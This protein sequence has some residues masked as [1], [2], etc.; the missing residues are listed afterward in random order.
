[1]D[2][3]PPPGMRWAHTEMGRTLVPARSSRSRRVTP[4]TALKHKCRAALTAWRQRA[5]LPVVLL[6]SIVGQVRVNDGS[7]RG[8]AIGVG[9]KGQADDTVLVLGAALAVEYK[10]GAD[11]QS[12]HQQRFQERW[13]AAGGIYIVC[14]QPT[15]LTDA[16]TQIAAQRG[17]I[18]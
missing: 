7:A 16:L 1:M 14:R 9:K 8:R 15:D 18:F 10:A 12:E 11:R 6:P 5:N 3:A 17:L 13:E 2:D 4:H